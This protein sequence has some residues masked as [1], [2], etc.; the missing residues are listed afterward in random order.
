MKTPYQ[1][2]PGC[3][4]RRFRGSLPLRRQPVVLNYRFPTPEAATRVPRRDM[5]LRQCATCGLVFNA[6][7]DPRVIPYDAD[8]ENRQCFSE[9]FN[10]HLGHLADSLVRDHRLRGRS[11]LEVGCGKGDFLR[12]ICRKARSKGVGY[13]TSFEPGTTGE[14]QGLSFH[15]EY[16][17]SES[18]PGTF[19]AVIC[20]HVVEHVPGIGAFLQ[21]LR[22]IGLAAKARVVFLETPRWEWIVEH[23]AFWDV[24]HEHCNYFPERSLAHLCQLAGFRV[25]RQR[26]VFGGQYQTLE[27]DPNPRRSHHPRPPGI[28]SGSALGSFARRF[29]RCQSALERSIRARACGQPWGLWGAGAKGVAMVN[30]LPRTR[31]ALVVDS[32]P[33]KQGGVIPGTRIPIVA[34][35]DPRLVRLSFLLIANPNYLEEIQKTLRRIRFTGS[36]GT[37]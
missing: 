2:C 13:D 37:L 1:E 23:R 27:L 24:F 33:S 18:V 30:Q 35:E 7:F 14:P 4:A 29:S 17:D 34:P 28:H 26:S 21:E 12:I 6:T 32:N 19:A 8:Y 10:A 25:L 22:A 36:V 5:L 31:P 11:I 3:G 15:R 20:R 16:L 9:A